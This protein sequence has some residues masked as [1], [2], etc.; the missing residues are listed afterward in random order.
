MKTE[1]EIRDRVK[2]LELMIE[3]DPGKSDLYSKWL[4]AM[5]WVLE[6]YCSGMDCAWC[7]DTECINM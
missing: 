4:D 7:S 6:E 5:H 2:D 3:K 1:K